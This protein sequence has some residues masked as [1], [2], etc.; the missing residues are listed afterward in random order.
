MKM[1]QKN[2][3]LDYVE[4]IDRIADILTIAER[5]TPDRTAY[6]YKKKQETLSATFAQF[7][8]RVRALG[9]ALAKNGWDALHIGCV[10]E[11]SYNWLTVYLT[12]LTSRGVFLPVDKELPAEDMLHVLE[13]GEAGV[14]FYSKRFE[15]FFRENE[16]RL[17]NVRA[18][19]G[20]DL[21][22]GDG[23][24]YS[25]E[26]LLAQGE[27]LLDSGYAEFT[28]NMTASDPDEMKMLVYTSGTTGMA[29]GVMLSETNLVSLVYYGP[30]ISGIG[31]R[32]L[33]VLPYHHTYEGVA[34]IL[35]A[36]HLHATVCIN[37]SMAAILKNMKEY[38]PSYLYLVPAFLDVFYKRIRGTME[39]EGKWEK[40]E[41]ARALSNKMR[42]VGIDLR[43][44]LFKAI[45]LVFGGRLKKIVV[46][47]APLRPDVAAFFEDVGLLVCNG[48]GITECTPLV[49]VNRDRFSDYRTV[50]VKMPCV[51]VK[52][53]HP[54]EDGNGEICVRGKTVMLGYYKNPEETARVL[55]D[56]WFHTGDL[57]NINELGQISITG[58]CKNLVVLDNG[59]NVYPEEIENYAATLPYVQEV[60]VSGVKDE[61][62]KT[63]LQAEIFPAKD[64]VET[65]DKPLTEREV[66]VDLHRACAPL[67]GYKQ[68]SRVV[69]RDSEFEK[70][71]TNKIKRKY[72]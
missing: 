18:F 72:N 35:V 69:L 15:A 42:K 2:Y 34:G 39:K 1:K 64:V 14:V 43:P 7:G 5:E 12:G 21:A 24:F 48:Y 13:H 29:K 44:K 55:V 28:D 62:G 20:F 50:G 16:A 59:K 45:H 49:S 25:F 11:N 22:E 26:E 37:D 57:G 3:P 58:R 41:K 52:I 66:L 10:G 19:I 56:G 33:S 67:P 36:L 61:N 9:S 31:D 23:R 47:G 32:C 27:K 53:D 38:R 51:D 40:F 4:K 17:Q 70:T 46:G 8:R 6:M 71:T 63:I 54:G 60:L 65:L 68:I 30:Q